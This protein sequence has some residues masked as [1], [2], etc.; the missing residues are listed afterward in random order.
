MNTQPTPPT[1]PTEAEIDETFDYIQDRLEDP[2]MSLIANKG[3]KDGYEAALEVLEGNMEMKDI[4]DMRT[5]V[6]ARAIAVLA[7][8]YLKGECTQE[9]LICIP[10]SGLLER[11]YKDK[12]IAN[13]AETSTL[14]LKQAEEVLDHFAWMPFKAKKMLSIASG[15]G[16]D[17]YEYFEEAKV[18]YKGFNKSGK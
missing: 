5:S 18:V 9:V 3:V 2:R 4:A 16:K 12:L 11:A 17:A 14:N 15:I 13:L 7:L 8:D 1:P 10:L 6:Q